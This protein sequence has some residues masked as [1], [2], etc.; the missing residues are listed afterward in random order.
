MKARILRRRLIW[1]VL[2]IASIYGFFWFIGQKGDFQ[3]P[4][5]TS[6]MIAA[7]QYTKTGSL[8]SVVKN[9][10]TIVTPDT[11]S[12]K[13]VSDRDIAWDPKG[14][15]LFFISDRKDSSFH[16]FRWDPA[17]NGS[18]DQ[19]SVDKAGRSNLAF[20]VQDKGIGELSGLV[21]V[22]GTVQEFF[23]KTAKSTTVMPPSGKAQMAVTDEA[24]GAVGGAGSNME[25]MYSRYGVSF[26]VAK[27]FG[28]RQFIAAV[29]RREDGGESLIVQDLTPDD[30]GNQR[31]PQLLFIAEKINLQVDPSGGALVFS[32]VNTYPM[33]DEKGNLQ[34]LP[35]RNG[36]FI[37]DPT[38]AD[39]ERMGPLFFAPTEELAVASFA[40]SPDG[41]LLLAAVGS[42]TKEGT[43][44]VKGLLTC[45]LKIGG[46]QSMTPILAGAVADPCFSP[47][48]DK[49]AFVKRE[50]TKRSI[51]VA[52]VD[53]SDQRNLTGDKGDFANPVFSP[54]YKY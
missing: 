31:A 52:K 16:I 42:S 47:K 35:F 37:L 10:G 53:G 13:L 30:K 21:T 18:P 27:W 44:E 12:G 15:R 38:K 14:N 2:L 45:P 3:R 1:F 41:S 22:R 26:R 20:D 25:L 34:K 46:G 43:I 8:V 48:G 9:D 40:V 7:V 19:K 32:L 29:M 28:N 24:S 39:A 51:F 17:H 54:Q 50:G 11:E 6:D 33:P 4:S 23:P 36:L 49:I 5:D